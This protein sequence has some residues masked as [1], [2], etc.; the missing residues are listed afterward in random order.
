MKLAT[1]TEHGRTRIG[2]VVGDRI[3]GTTESEPMQYMIRR[4]VLPNHWSESRPLNAVRLE[5]PIR[6]GKI[7]AIGK[8]YAEHAKE[9]GGSVPTAPIIFAKFSSSIIATGDAITWSKRITNQVDWEGELAVVIG[10]KAR[11]VSEADAL[12]HVF[13][14]TV[15]HDVSARD[16]QLRTDSQWTRGKSL[17]TFCPLGPW[18]VTADEVPDPQ[19][20]NISTT[21]NGKVVQKSNTK[22]MIFSIPYLIH[23][24]SQM[25][26]LEPG[27]LI[28]TGTPEGVGE[29]MKPPQ[30]LNDGDVVEIEVESV[31]KLSNPCVVTE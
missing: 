4:G 27:D 7:V 10:Q 22:N 23:Y 30:Y 24:C 5:A 25:F 1:F 28:L 2:E 18:I 14:Y 8:N 11:N 29:G 21:V 9:T 15:A 19:N 3:H 17:D 31:G 6:P 20:L 26:T 16:L 12:K 13:G